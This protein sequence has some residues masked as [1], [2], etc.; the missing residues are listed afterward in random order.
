MYKVSDCRE[1]EERARERERERENWKGEGCTYICASV[2]V[3]ESREKNMELLSTESWI[4][5]TFSISSH[6]FHFFVFRIQSRPHKVSDC[7]KG[8]EEGR[9]DLYMPS[10]FLF[11]RGEKR[12]SRGR[13]K[14]FN[15]CNR[16]DSAKS[17][18]MIFRCDGFL[19]GRRIMGRHS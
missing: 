9:C 5:P 14:D 1:R 18:T 10:Q 8:R 3:I 19:S 15:I 17:S 16:E 4:C 12:T 7:R 11:S 13:L 2:I 6:I